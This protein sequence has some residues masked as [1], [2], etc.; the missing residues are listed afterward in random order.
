MEGNVFL[1]GAKP[2]RF[3]QHPLVKADFDP[4]LRLISKED[5]LYLEIKLERSWIDTEPRKLV[6]SALLGRAA[7]PDLPYEEADGS[8][9]SIDFDYFGKARKKSN[10]APGPF[11]YPSQGN[12]MLKVAHK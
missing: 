1:D 8:S 2:S 6:T 3:E 4:G 12:L 9:V 7:I 11:E 5:G 10:P